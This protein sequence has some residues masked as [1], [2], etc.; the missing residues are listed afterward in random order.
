[1]EI[2]RDSKKAPPIFDKKPLKGLKNH[3]PLPVP[4]LEIS[5]PFN[6]LQIL[7]KN[8]LLIYLLH[9]IFRNHFLFNYEKSG[10]FWNGNLYPQTYSNYLFSNLVSC[11][12][13]ILVA[14]YLE[15]KKIYFR[16]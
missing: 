10:N 7:G 15:N 2:S 16:V 5:F 3:Q 14:Y 1:M 8:S 13:W 12:I 6:T 4:Y 9:L 11:Y